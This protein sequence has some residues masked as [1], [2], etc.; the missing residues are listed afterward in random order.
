MR[1]DGVPIR[2]QDVQENLTFYIFLETISHMENLTQNLWGFYGL[3]VQWWPLGPK[4][5]VSHPAENVGYLGRK[6]P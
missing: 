5:A 3:E 1:Y 4:F 2:E 6:N